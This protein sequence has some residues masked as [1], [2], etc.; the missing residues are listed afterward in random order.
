MNRK[1][2]SST[3]WN[4]NPDDLISGKPPH[5]THRRIRSSLGNRLHVFAT[6]AA[7]SPLLSFKRGSAAYSNKS[8]TISKVL[9]P[10]AKCSGVLPL[11]ATADGFA[12]RCSNHLVSFTCPNFELQCSGVSPPCVVSI[13][14]RRPIPSRSTNSSTLSC[15]PCRAAYQI[16]KTYLCARVDAILSSRGIKKIYLASPSNISPVQKKELTLDTNLN[17]NL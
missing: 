12:P 17:F 16:E 5:G 13:E 4:S 10:A 11:S 7:V 15:L 14:L 9:L 6:S 2:C 1:L 8:R 3:R